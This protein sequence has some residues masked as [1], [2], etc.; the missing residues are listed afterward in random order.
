[1]GVFENL[2]YTNFHELNLDWIVKK[3]RDLEAGHYDA[4][5]EKVTGV[6]GGDVADLAVSAFSVYKQNNLVA[7]SMTAKFNGE[8]ILPGLSIVTGFPK[9]MDAMV[10]PAVWYDNATYAAAAIDVQMDANGNII[11]GSGDTSD[12]GAND[13]IIIGLSYFAKQE[14]E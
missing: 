13:M 3:I 4:V 5:P 8:T 12:I 1:M 14:D 11:I 6:T 9:P 2:P 7:G 10:L